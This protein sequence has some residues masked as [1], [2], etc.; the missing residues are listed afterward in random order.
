M[1]EKEFFK[2]L[3]EYI[4][5]LRD[6]RDDVKILDFVVE[7]LDSIPKEVQKFICE[8]TG[9]MEISL[10]NTINFYPR[11]RSRVSDIKEVAVCTGMN[12]GPMGGYSIFNELASILEIDKNGV[13]KDGKIVLTTKRCFGR[14]SK[15]PNISVDGEIYSFM[16]LQ[17]IKRKLGL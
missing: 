8:K 2:E 4:E 14:C 10:E 1:V 12:C 3:E 9:M 11:F 5:G 13:S 6:K 7:R 16:N 15:G 17:D